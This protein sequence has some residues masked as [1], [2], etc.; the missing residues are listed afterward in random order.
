MNKIILLSLVSIMSL[1]CSSKKYLTLNSIVKETKANNTFFFVPNGALIKSFPI[2]EKNIEYTVGVLNNKAIYI[3]TTDKNFTISGL[4][5]N[6]KLPE[7]YF[8]GEWGYRA[9]WGYYIEIESGWYAGFDFKTKPNRDSRVQ[10]FFKF[11][12]NK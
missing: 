1:S 6:D 10:W 5:I 2:I 8:V 12:F 4:K 7:S 9:G 11:D 3:G